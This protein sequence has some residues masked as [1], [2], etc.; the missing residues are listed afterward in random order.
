MNSQPDTTCPKC[1]APAPCVDYSEVD[2]GV[3]V[4][5]FDHE[6]QC[7][8]CGNFAFRYEPELNR[9]EAV[10]RQPST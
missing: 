2:I 4:Q 5:T 3:G 7:P 10:W 8:N 9:T 6:Y 1:G